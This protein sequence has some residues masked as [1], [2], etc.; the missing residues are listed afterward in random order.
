MGYVSPSWHWYE[1]VSNRG[2]SGELKFEGDM[3]PAVSA[4]LVDGDDE[5]H[6]FG[7]GV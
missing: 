7:S 1:T 6:D 4:F 3:G 5:G 2:Y